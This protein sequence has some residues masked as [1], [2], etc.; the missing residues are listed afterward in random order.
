VPNIHDPRTGRIVWTRIFLDSYLGRTREL[1]VAALGAYTRLLLRYIASKRPLPDND[2]ELARLA[3]CP[4]VEWR[5]LRPQLVPDLL[6]P[7]DGLLID[8][9]AE[10][11]I[12]QFEARSTKNAKAA[13]VRW[14]VIAGGKLEEGEL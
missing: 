9:L 4:L 6:Q 2:R 5:R 8:E 11:R 7:R 13:A 14:Q 12:D 10:E 3:G 1:S